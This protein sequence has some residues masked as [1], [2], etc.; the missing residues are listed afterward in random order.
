MKTQKNSIL[1]QLYAQYY[2]EGPEF[3]NFRELVLCLD[4]KDR[5][6]AWSFLKDVL[7][8]EWV[9]S[10]H[11]YH[12]KKQAEAIFDETL[13]GLDI[14]AKVIADCDLHSADVIVNDGDV[15]INR[16]CGMHTHFHLNQANAR[17]IESEISG[18][19]FLDGVKPNSIVFENCGAELFIMIESGWL[20]HVLL[21]NCVGSQFSL[22]GDEF[23]V[24]SPWFYATAEETM[25]NAYRIREILKIPHPTPS[26]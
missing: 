18:S 25:T 23:Q 15:T 26:L 10:F 6:I 20:N 9:D 13:N 3:F 12:K 2:H 5:D 1:E 11:A 21:I 4:S 7:G 14:H 24:K 8:S 16:C 19:V 22:W 17:I